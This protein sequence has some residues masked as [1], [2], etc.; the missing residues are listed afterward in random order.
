MFCKIEGKFALSQLAPF[1]IGKISTLDLLFLFGPKYIQDI[2]E[3][4]SIIVTRMKIKIISPGK[5]FLKS[6][7]SNV[8]T[9][10]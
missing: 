10:N 8:I 3:L 6:E 2:L 4:Y 7:K 1:D 5:F 9:D